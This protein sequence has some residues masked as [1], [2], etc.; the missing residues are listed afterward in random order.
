MKMPSA[1]P[2][3]SEGSRTLLTGTAVLLDRRAFTDDAQ[4]Q[5]VA[6]LS[7]G[8]ARVGQAADPVAVD[9]IAVHAG[10]SPLR[11]GLARWLAENDRPSLPGFF[12]L[13]ELVRI[14][15]TGRPVPESLSRWGNRETVLTG[16]EICGLL[17]RLP[18]ERYAGRVSN[19]MI[20][21]AVPDLQLALASALAAVDLPAVLVPDLMAAA[22]L[23]FVT[24]VPARHPDDWQAMVEWAAGLSLDTIER[25]LGL[26]TVDGP[27]RV[28]AE[29]RVTVR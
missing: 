28:A 1:P 19:G 6:W 21:Y 11:A 24:S 23:D 14:G 5:L 20:A 10:A 15:L 13:T 27:L 16:R 2:T 29:Q 26:L 9:L 12:S 4:R 17:P 3:L 18:W 25:Y 22:T 7:A 8:R